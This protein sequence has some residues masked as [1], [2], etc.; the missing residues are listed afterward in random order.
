MFQPKGLLHNCA[1]HCV[2]GGESM[3]DEQQL[4]ILHQG[5]EE[6]NKWRL[7]NR[8]LQPDLFK[9]EWI[10]SNLVGANLSAGNLS[11]AK[12][13]AANLGGADMTGAVIRWTSFGAIDLSAIKG[14]DTVT[15]GVLS[16]IGIYTLYK[17][18]GKSRRRSCAARAFR[19]TSSPT[20]ALSS[21]E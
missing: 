21:D 9:A 19:R 20:S 4:A 2:L 10:R 8:D 7:Q 15:N 18:H 11:S 14:L 1:A 13:V 5:V 3:A 17:S 6:W 12:F 16:S